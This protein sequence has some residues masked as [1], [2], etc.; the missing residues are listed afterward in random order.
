ML[1]YITDQHGLPGYMFPYAIGYLM[2]FFYSNVIIGK[3]S[4]MGMCAVISQFIII[5]ICGLIAF[6]QGIFA[7]NGLI[8]YFIGIACA[9]SIFVFMFRLLERVLTSNIVVWLSGISFEIYLVHEFFLGRFNVYHIIDAPIISF[10]L[11]IILSVTSAI[12]LSRLSKVFERRNPH[13]IK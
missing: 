12:V 6:K 2:I 10:I 3:I 13:I 1:D 7:T 8:A 5:N 9:C 11:L 4:K